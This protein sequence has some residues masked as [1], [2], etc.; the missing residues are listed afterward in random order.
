MKVFKTKLELLSYLNACRQKKSIG[1]VPTMGALHSGHLH[2]IERTKK[3]CKITICSIFVNPTQFNNV[4][5]FANYPKS[6]DTDLKK[7]QDLG[8]DIVYTPTIADLYAKGE[9]AKKF[10]FGT[11]ASGMEERFRPG[12]FNGMATIIEKFFNIIRPTK[13]FFGQKDLQQLQIIKALVRQ[14]NAPIEIVSIP[15]VREKNGVAKSSR[16]KLLSENAR[17]EAALIY[18]CLNYCLNNKEKGIIELKLY[19]HNKF[20]KQKNIKLEYAEIVDLNIML[21]INKWQAKNENAIC[22]AAYIE[23]VRLIDNIIL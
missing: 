1:F 8:C 18:S 17:N 6:L 12:H 21:P 2:L 7:L 14:M 19:I 4:D 11:L 13:A 15:T 16:N 3:D 10:D 9:K 5:D 22:I 23:G 20:K